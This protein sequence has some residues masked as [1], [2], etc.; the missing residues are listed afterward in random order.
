MTYPRHTW[1]NDP[2]GNTPVNKDRLREIENGIWAGSD[3]G[4]LDTGCSTSATRT[5][6]NDHFNG[7]VGTLPTIAAGQSRFARIRH[8]VTGGAQ[9]Y[10]IV[11]GNWYTQIAAGGASE[12]SGPSTLNIRA[13][14]EYL[15]TR[16]PVTFDEASSV[17]IPPGGWAIGEVT[18]GVA[19]TPGIPL[20]SLTLM[21]TSGTTAFP[22]GGTT[23]ATYDFSYT[24]TTPTPGAAGDPI[25]NGHL[26]PSAAN[27]SQFA[28][29]PMAILSNGD[30]GTVFMVGDSIV[31]GAGDF[32][33]DTNSGNLAEPG[34]YVAR[35]LIGVRAWRAGTYGERHDS[36]NGAMGRRAQIAAAHRKVLISLGTNDISAGQT[37]ATVVANMISVWEKYRATGAEVTAITIPPRT[38]AVGNNWG[39]GAQT[40]ATGNGAGSVFTQIRAWMLDGAPITVTYNGDGSITRTAAAVGAGFPLV[41]RCRIYQAPGEQTNSPLHPLTAIVDAMTAVLATN[42]WAWR[43][44]TTETTTTDGI[45]PSVSAHTHMSRLVR[46]AM[47]ALDDTEDPPP[48]SAAGTLP[49]PLNGWTFDPATMDSTGQVVLTAGS[50]YLFEVDLRAGFVSNVDFWVQTLSTAA[51]L[52]A[53]YVALFDKYRNRQAITADVQTTFETAGEKS[54]S[55]IA[56][57]AVAAGRYYVGFLGVGFALSLR[58]GIAQGGLLNAGRLAIPYRSAIAGT[59]L[60]TIP[61]QASATQTAQTQTPL[62]LVR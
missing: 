9:V 26:A 12:Q 49:Y 55:F 47:P 20:Y 28:F 37:Y 45:H 48:P 18:L 44:N 3:R 22:Y 10:K 33:L 27:V 11:Y 35:A 42:G 60:S 43:A 15:G 62:L 58:A 53:A 13:A 51:S 2:V 52:T 29:W 1:L 59:G 30:D 56:P 40:G 17:A 21:S 8:E 19:A 41:V 34:G 36:M 54:V 14:V 57:T 16:Y 5:T 7:T 50:M 25:T 4:F 31:A 23:N 39:S 46:N 38:T 24:M 32:A 6:V 61:T